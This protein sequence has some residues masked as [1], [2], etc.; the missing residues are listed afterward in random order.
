MQGVRWKNVE[1]GLA[2]QQVVQFSDNAEVVD[3]HGS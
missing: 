3:A 1:V 2:L